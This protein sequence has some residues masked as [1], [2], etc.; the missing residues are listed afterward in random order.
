MP[1]LFKHNSDV[2][3]KKMPASLVINS[4]TSAPSIAPQ[5]PASSIGTPLMGAPSK[6]GFSCMGPQRKPAAATRRKFQT[7]M[8]KTQK[9][10]EHQLITTPGCQITATNMMKQKT[11]APPKGNCDVNHL[12]KVDS[13]HG[14]KAVQQGSL[15]Q[16]YKSKK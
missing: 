15:I 11:V 2:H 3:D 9:P 13:R 10:R 4:L 1:D 6:M 7:S 16:R 14:R 12:L 5:A 8:I